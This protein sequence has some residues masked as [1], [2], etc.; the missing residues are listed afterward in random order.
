MKHNLS[1]DPLEA[2]VRPIGSLGAEPQKK[3]PFKQHIG[4]TSTTCVAACFSSRCIK[5]C[6]EADA[7]IFLV[8]ARFHLSDVVGVGTDEKFECPS[9]KH[10]NKY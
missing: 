8:A 7:R 6:V 4:Q 1:L 9:K 2:N 10:E 5:K 3:R